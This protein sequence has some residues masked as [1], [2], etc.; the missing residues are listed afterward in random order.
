VSRRRIS[1]RRSRGSGRR[2]ARGRDRT[3]LWVAA[4]GG[5]LWLLSRNQ[6]TAAA[7]SISPAGVPSGGILGSIW[8][9]VSSALS[10]VTGA[11]GGTAGSFWSSLFSPG[12]PQV[13]Q[14][15]LPAPL[16]PDKQ[17]AAA[18]DQRFTDTHGRF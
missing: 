18:A 9:S 1:K 5:L 2:R 12:A 7:P 16:T 6:V 3:L 10:S 8:S 17:G 15:A 4:G 13:A 11:A 14:A